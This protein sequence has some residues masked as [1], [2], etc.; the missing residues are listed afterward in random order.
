[1]Y[2]VLE[3]LVPVW[4]LNARHMHNV[5]GRKTDLADADW[6]CQLVEYGLV[7]P[8]FV[9]PKPIR[10]LRDLTRYRKAQIQER[11]REAQRLDKVLQD[12]GVK[13]SSVASDTLGASGR[14][15]LNALVAGTT[16]PLVLADL[17][18]GRLRSKLPALHEA[19][20]GRFDAH[21]ALLVSAVLSKLDFLDE[22]IGRLSDQIEVLIAPFGRQVDLLTTIPGVQARTAQ[23]ILAEISPDMTV[24]GSSRRLASWAGKCPGNYES[25]GKQRKGTTRKGSRWLSGY[26]HDA[27]MAA[28]RTKHC[29]LAAQYHHLR[30][31]TGHARAL[32]A[33]EHSL[34]VAIYC[35]LDRD[36]PYHDLGA[37]YLT[38]RNDPQRQAN[39]LI[40][41]LQRL[42]YRVQ[43]TPPTTPT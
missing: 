13:L 8:S 19:L 3:D 42:G 34:L 38:H 2:Y 22:L 15:M 31:R 5:P 32:V 35:M 21:H 18:R 16:D 10:Q 25:A 28:I 36:Q 20:A 33:F 43:A 7:R 11:S 26:L 40:H 1:V 17:A 27:A 9:P 37:D 4:L 29:Y 23:G 39:R 14:A 24:F 12:A 6:I 41:Q 30:P